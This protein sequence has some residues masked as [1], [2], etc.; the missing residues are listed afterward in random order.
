MLLVERVDVG[1]MIQQ[2][3]CLRHIPFRRHVVQQREWSSS[4]DWIHAGSNRRAAISVC[5]K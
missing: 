2:Q 1:A 4:Y 3:A 5:L